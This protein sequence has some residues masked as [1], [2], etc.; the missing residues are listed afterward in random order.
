MSRNSFV[1]TRIWETTDYTV[2]SD[3]QRIQSRASTVMMLPKGQADLGYLDIRE[4]RMPNVL[5][6]QARCEL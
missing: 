4:E 2:A 1:V 6:R 3:S 5:V